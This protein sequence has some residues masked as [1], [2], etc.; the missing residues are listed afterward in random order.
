MQNLKSIQKHNIPLK[1]V[2][3]ILDE[4]ENIMACLVQAWI[5]ITPPQPVCERQ[6]AFLE[7]DLRLD[8]GCLGQRQQ[9]SQALLGT[10]CRYNLVQSDHR[11]WKVRPQF[12]HHLRLCHRNA[13][14]CHWTG[15]SPN[16]ARTKNAQSLFSKMLERLKTIIMV[17]IRTILLAAQL[18]QASHASGGPS[19]S[20]CHAG[21]IE[22][23]LGSKGKQFQFD[24]KRPIMSKKIRKTFTRNIQG[25]MILIHLSHTRHKPALEAHHYTFCPTAASGSS[26]KCR[27]QQKC[28]DEWHQ[29]TNRSE[30]SQNA[31]PK[32]NQPPDHLGWGAWRSK[33]KMKLS[34]KWIMTDRI[35]KRLWLRISV[36]LQNAHSRNNK[37]HSTDKIFA[38]VL[39]KSLQVLFHLFAKTVSF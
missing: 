18:H 32:P 11:V 1:N 28:P 36:N 5:K 23:R 27:S 12:C 9:I 21:R 26:L 25:W 8:L 20:Q 31:T 17:A 16:P 33:P 4:Q 30:S 22:V 19:S 3:S 24:T 39:N 13:Q 35:Q 10:H 7:I 34:F 14:V 38:T 29:A 37:K 6:K 15:S 2:V